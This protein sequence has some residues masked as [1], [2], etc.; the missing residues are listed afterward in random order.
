MR[1]L[2]ALVGAAV[3]GFAG[4]GWYMGWY[5]VKVAKSGDG[6]IQVQG[7]LDTNRVVQDAGEGAKRV[8]ELIGS[9]GEKKADGPSS[10]A[11]TPAP[12]AGGGWLFG[13][14]DAPADPKATGKR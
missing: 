8:G 14:W 5:T 10:P 3:V 13:D 4:V 1:N 2:L 9:Q 7:N 11:N 6:T 12:K